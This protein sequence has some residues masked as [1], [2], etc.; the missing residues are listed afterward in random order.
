M[1]VANISQEASLNDQFKVLCE[2]KLSEEHRQRISDVYSRCNEEVR[3]K[4]MAS[5]A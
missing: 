1:I 3:Q 2:N 4:V 5:L